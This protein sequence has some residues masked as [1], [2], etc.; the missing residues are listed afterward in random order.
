M[1]ETV[2]AIAVKNLLGRGLWLLIVDLV[3]GK[4]HDGISVSVVSIPSKLP[5]IPLD[6]DVE[7]T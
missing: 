4:V 5:R 7:K 2:K 1:G 3:D 6:V